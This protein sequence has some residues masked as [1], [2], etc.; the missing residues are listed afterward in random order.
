MISKND[1]LYNIISVLLSFVV[2]FRD[3]S[4]TPVP[5]TLLPN[6]VTTV[7]VTWNDVQKHG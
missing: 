2:G 3:F 4:E 5:Q 6:D 7:L 1:P